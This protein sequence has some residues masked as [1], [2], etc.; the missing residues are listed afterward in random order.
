M[1][2]HEDNFKL[3]VDEIR[4]G[5]TVLGS[6]PRRV[7]VALTTACNI[8]C[9]MCEVKKIKWELP[10]RTLD[11]IFALFPYMERVIWQGGEV[12]LYKRFREVLEEAARSPHLG[13]EITTNAHLLNDEWLSLLGKLKVDVNVSV[14]ATDGPTY[15]YI[16]A[17]SRFANITRNLEALQQAGV[18]SERVL[19]VTVMRSNHDKLDGFIDFAARYGFT[20]I[21]LQ[22]VKANDSTDE[23]I[24]RS[25]EPALMGRLAGTVASLRGRAAA[26]GIEFVECLPLPRPAPD[27]GRQTPP[28][29][30]GPARARA[31]Y[32]CYAPWQQ[33]FI[34]WG[35][36]VYPHCL[37]I[38]DG[39]NEVRKAGNVKVSSLADIWNG[40]KMREYRQRIVEMKCPGLCN[41]ACLQGIISANMRNLYID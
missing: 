9:R 37:C 15:E 36:W 24:F 10:D 22:P 18:G 5:K 28:A 29:A 16:R 4:A 34:E 30:N 7:N 23:N 33:L 21:I 19:L 8:D 17:G 27:G 39:D 11:E 6:K 38:G 2:L 26:A 31:E 40:E 3:N 35:G 14:D 25:P 13:H 32:I 1:A 12:F 41:Q 20:R